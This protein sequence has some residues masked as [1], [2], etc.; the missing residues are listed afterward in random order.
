VVTGKLEA[1]LLRFVLGGVRQPAEFGPVASPEDEPKM[2]GLR[3]ETRG[4]RYSRV[5]SWF[6]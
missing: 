1:D 3:K 4:E 6:A 5:E 2:E